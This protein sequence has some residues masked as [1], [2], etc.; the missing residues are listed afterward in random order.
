MGFEQQ[1]KKA[2]RRKNAGGVFP[3]AHKNM[4]A[5]ANVFAQIESERQLV[6]WLYL[7]LKGAFK[8]IGSPN[9]IPDL[10]RITSAENCRPHALRIYGDGR[11]SWVEY[12]LGYPA[13]NSTIWLWQPVPTMLNPLFLNVLQHVGYNIPFLSAK[14]KQTLFKRITRP[15]KKVTALVRQIIARR[16]SLF[17]YFTHCIQVDPSVS[18]LAKMVLLPTEKQHH[19]SARYYQQENSDRLRFRIFTAYERYLMRLAHC[20]KSS[21]FIGLFD[22]SLHDM[23]IA[24]VFKDKFTQ[25]IYLSEIEGRILQYRMQSE[26][27]SRTYEPEPSILIGTNRALSDVDAIQIFHDLHQDLEKLKPAKRAT[28]SDWIRYYNHMTYCL[29]LQFIA[30]TGAR[31]THSIGFER[32]RCFGGHTATIAD[33]GKMRLVWICEFLRGQIEHYLAVQ[34]QIRLRL[35]TSDVQQPASLFY[36]IDEPTLQIAPLNAKNLRQFW[37]RYHPQKIPYQLRHHFA[38]YALNYGP[39]CELSTQDIDLLMGHNRF[40][41]H[42][43]SQELFP[44]Q[45]NRFLKHLDQLAHR[46]QLRRFS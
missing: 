31:P 24:N 23:R 46:L 26:K 16:L 5:L 37:R 21:E 11:Q 45:T 35:S 42:L 40:G 12:A 1:F 4:L 13:K 7:W 39:Q 19:Q 8:T 43:G 17:H 33:K 30:L 18:T 20:A 22:R 27:Q 15:P 36:L 3:D 25:A 38:Q 14:E 2:N 29:A 28:R 34:R 44:D 41:E 9:D 10:I 32:A 6:V